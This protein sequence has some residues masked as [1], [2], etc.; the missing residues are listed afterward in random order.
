[1]RYLLFL[2]ICSSVVACD[3]NGSKEEDDIQVVSPPD[4]VQLV[5]GGDTLTVT[6]AGVFR[7]VTG[8]FGAVLSVT[9]SDTAI[10]A[11]IR[12]SNV[13][14]WA[15]GPA[16]STVTLLAQTGDA[17]AA[18]SFQA[19]SRDPLVAPLST[20]ITPD[21][22]LYASRDT[23][24]LDASQLF[25]VA[26]GKQATFEL[27]TSSKPG[28]S[29]TDEHLMVTSLSG[30]TTHFTVRARV[31]E[32]IAERDI[33]IRFTSNWCFTA[34]PATRSYFDLEANRTYIY[35]VNSSEYKQNGFTRET[36][37]MSG[38]VTWTIGE[39]GSCSLG[40]RTVQ[41]IETL[42]LVTSGKTTTIV[43]GDTISSK[44]RGPERIASDLSYSF[45][46]TEQLP[47]SIGRYWSIPTEPTIARYSAAAD[48]RIEVTFGGTP[49]RCC[50][51]STTVVLEKQSAPR[52]YESVRHLSSPGI[53]ER[54]SFRFLIRD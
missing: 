10:Q 3:S 21:T 24:R 38:T 31:E 47:Y 20:P 52:L 23:F 36:N 14:I 35:D 49:S 42:D 34:P 41:L 43:N 44:K 40:A 4:D 19:A 33:T 53:N 48:D 25:G 46:L 13:I 9:S 28:V 39:L 12:G 16:I 7:F 6:T 32:D 51:S 22:S 11:A 45:M 27:V 5:T 17:Q 1:M 26:D 29:L 18:V 8:S 2:L 30:G 15:D 50:A 54:S 37:T